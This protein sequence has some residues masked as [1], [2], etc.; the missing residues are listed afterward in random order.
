MSKVRGNPRL[1][2]LDR[3]LGIPAVRLLSLMPKRAMPRELRRI[4]IL[5]TAAV[6]DTLLLRG[7]LEDI[8]E[9]RP[10]ARVVLITGRNNAQAG[11]LIAAGV[12]EQVVIPERNPVV[13]L[14]AI[15]PLALDVLVDT[16]SWPRLDAVLAA[17]SGAAFRVGFRTGGQ[18]RHHAYDATVEHAPGL[19]EADN[20][21]AL[22]RAIGIDSTRNPSL[23]DVPLPPAP[24][25]PGGPYIVFHPW[26]GGYRGCLKEW[27]A[28]RWI[29]LAQELGGRIVVTGAPAETSKTEGLVSRLRAGAVDASALTNI[30]LAEVA[31]VLKGARAVVSVNTGVMHLSAMV[32]AATVCLDGPTPPLRW[33]P[34][35]PRVTSVSSSLPGCGYLHLGFEYEGQ[36]T[37]CMLGIDVSRVAAAVRALI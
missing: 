1:K 11:A 18:S 24:F 6:G 2:F 19:H 17:L 37:D 3:A 26:S 8:R 28:E 31:T 36:R 13:A 34:I 16:G 25:A 12:A 22:F 20:F 15:R 29:G 4:G 32:G 33:G 10:G 23:R 5:R 35:G 30:G 7:V 9:Q 27:P 21:R 14:A